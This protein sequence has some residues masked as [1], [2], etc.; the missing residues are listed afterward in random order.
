MANLFTNM[1]A[2]V[3]NWLGSQIAPFINDA[4]GM[5]GNI[6]SRYY[7]GDHREQLKTKVGAQNDN[8]ILNFIGL[9]VDRSVSRLFRGGIDFMLPEG[10]DAQQEYLDR[11]WDIN[12]KEILLYQYGLHGAVYGTCY[13]KIAPDGILDPY[14]NE[15]LP[16]L[17]ALDPEIVRI[18]VSPEDMNEVEQ[19]IIK[20]S[21]LDV[22]GGREVEITHEEIVRHSRADDYEQ[23]TGPEQEQPDTWQI[24]EWE[25]VGGAPREMVSIQEWAYT[26]PPIVH[27]KNLPSLKSAYGDSDI[28]DVIN[29]QDKEN[30]TVSNMGKIIKFHAHP[31]T[32]GTGFAVKDMQKLEAEVG[33][34]HAIPNEK[35][36]VFNLEMQSDLASSQAF[37]L[38]LRQSIFDISREVDISSMA[39]KVDALTNFGLQV[40]WSDAIDKNDTKRQL[41]GDAL[42][43]LN[44]RLLVMAGYE[45]A[46]SDP[47]YIQWGDPLPV[48]IIE[49][50]TADEKALAMGIIDIETVAARYEN[51]YGVDYETV[52]AN[53]A[54]QKETDNA[55]NA[56][57]GAMILRNF[58]QGQ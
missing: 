19:Y 26:F 9:A 54:A 34:F 28:D 40:L 55:N 53:I 36:K 4:L 39:D 29:V 41:Y 20:Y 42:L 10:A 58:N 6:L 23:T 30:F 27:Q 7:S 33:S 14:T 51:R 37:A 1:M 46:A 16:R 49:E 11:V 31:E 13:F 18:K 50:M 44:R 22:R 8:V 32:I 15:Y 57:V 5:R 17:I 43:E 12:K 38:T 2:T 56:N 25:Q 47:G 24:E 52:K 21:Y 48:N 45:L 3:G 35:A